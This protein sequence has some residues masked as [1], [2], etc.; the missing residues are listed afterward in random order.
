MIAFTVY[1]FL[2]EGGRRLEF[3]RDIFADSPVDAM[4]Q[5]LRAHASLMVSGVCRARIQGNDWY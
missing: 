3:M 1:G 2:T 4:E 5:A